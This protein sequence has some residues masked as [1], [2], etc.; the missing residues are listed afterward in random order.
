MRRGPSWGAGSRLDG[1]SALAYLLALPGGTPHQA[2]ASQKYTGEVLPALPGSQ[3]CLR[4]DS[5]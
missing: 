5:Q 3:S 1:G 2:A 4:K